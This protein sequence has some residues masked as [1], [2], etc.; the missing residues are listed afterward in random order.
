MGILVAAAV[1]GLKGDL[2]RALVREANAFWEAYQS[3][4]KGTAYDDEK[5][6]PEP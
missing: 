2:A 6:E 5:P 3:R 4:L 1:L